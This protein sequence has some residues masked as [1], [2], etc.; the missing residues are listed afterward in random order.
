M[1]LY[2]WAA[3]HRIPFDALRELQALFLAPLSEMPPIPEGMSETAA[4]Q[5]V[6]IEAAQKGARLW[7]NNVGA[8]VDEHGN[9]F[10]FGLANDSA[11]VNNKIKSSDLIGIRP[12][13]I[14]PRHVGSVIGQFLSREVKAPGWTWSATER[15]QAQ[16]RWLQLVAAFGG[17]A[18]FC[19]GPGTL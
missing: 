16:L 19:T 14:E 9:Y 11:A 13:V 3:R 7:R 5:R 4:S 1:T 2:E 12:I 6:R 15:E 18:C 8:A 17:D 10:R